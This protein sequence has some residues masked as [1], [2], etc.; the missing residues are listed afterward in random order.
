MTLKVSTIDI[1]KT[2][3]SWPAGTEFKPAL[4]QPRDKDSWLVLDAPHTPGVQPVWANT[5]SDEYIRI[6]VFQYK[7]NPNA[8]LALAFMLHLGLSFVG[9]VERKIKKLHI[10]TADPVELIYDENNQPQ[11]MICWVGF[12]AS[13][14]DH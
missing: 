11:Y 13:F 12:A 1:N 10:V 5:D 8:D 9:Y 4:V 6:P 2:R 7:L 3:E 14:G